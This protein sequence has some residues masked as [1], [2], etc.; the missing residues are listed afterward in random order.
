MKAQEVAIAIGVVLAVILVVLLGGTIFEAGRNLAA[1]GG[2]P[3][4][5]QPA[6]TANA[7]PMAAPPRVGPQAKPAIFDRERSPCEAGYQ[8]Y[9][10]RNACVEHHEPKFVKK[11]KC[12]VGDVK[13]VPDP[14]RPGGKREQ[15]CGFAPQAASN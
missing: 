13:W 9:P 11:A 8:W 14:S 1:S 4:G 5:Y 7:A 3:Q 12:E 6:G 2:S 15:T 10:E